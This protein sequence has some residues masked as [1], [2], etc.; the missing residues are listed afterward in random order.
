MNSKFLDQYKVLV[1]EDGNVITAAGKHLRKY[2][3][4]YGYWMVSTYANGKRKNLY[5]HRLIAL[6]FIPNPE[7]KPQV[8]HINA[9]KSDYSLLN[10]EWCTHAE[11]LHH[12][13]INKLGC[14]RPRG[15]AEVKRAMCMRF[16]YDTGKF[17]QI[18][19]AEIFGLSAPRISAIL[20]TV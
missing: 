5:I 17:T 18:E 1:F 4:R 10:L 12:A 20:K 19:I 11:N 16:L 14:G 8:N 2:Q 15:P 9:I 7:N 3:D 6:A 13:K